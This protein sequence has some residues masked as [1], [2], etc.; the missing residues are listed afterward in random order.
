[1]NIERATAK[2]ADWIDGMI[3]REFPY[4]E[5]TPAKIAERM[6]DPKY[7]VFVAKQ[8]N[9]IAGF[10][11]LEL[12]PENKEARLNAIFVDDGWRDQGVAKMMIAKCINEGKHK[13][14][15]RIF[16]LVRT[17]NLGAK[18]LY[19]KTGFKFESIHD[20]IIDNHE[21]EV[22]GQEI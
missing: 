5:F 13:K 7:I 16:L 19:G 17:D 8:K 18:H 21:V 4:T 3:K 22:W 15:Q 20:K 12:F 11:E 9:I 1:M 10:C 14:I 2:E 6:N